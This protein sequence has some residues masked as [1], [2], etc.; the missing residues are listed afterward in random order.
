MA[1]FRYLTMDGDLT[2]ELQGA[3]GRFSRRHKVSMDQDTWDGIVGVR[4]EIL[5]PDTHWFIP[6]YL[7]VGTGDSN[8]TWQALLGVGYRF[9]WGEVTVAMRSLSY[10]FDKNDA[11]LTLVG[12]GLGVGF[13]W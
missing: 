1:G 6:Y 8:W 5:F 3:D 12:P 4:G 9:N 7:D 11:D 13:R 2:L 10:D